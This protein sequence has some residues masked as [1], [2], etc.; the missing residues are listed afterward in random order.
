VFHYRQ[1]LHSMQQGLSD[2]AIAKSGLMG[3]QKVG[4]LRHLARKPAGNS[5]TTP[6]QKISSF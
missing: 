1:A 2:R 5:R 6:T 3:R 4:Q